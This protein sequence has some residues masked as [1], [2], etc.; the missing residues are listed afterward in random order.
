MARAG[1]KTSLPDNE[2]LVLTQPSTYASIHM[3]IS[4]HMRL[5]SGP[6]ASFSD[7]FG[8]PGIGA[9]SDADRRIEC[10]LSKFADDMKLSSAVDTIGQHAIQRHTDKPVDWAHEDFRKFNKCKVLH[11][12]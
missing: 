1:M 2:Q 12:E 7:Q 6:G 4:M 11:L 10:T 9:N 5:S 8:M 3:H